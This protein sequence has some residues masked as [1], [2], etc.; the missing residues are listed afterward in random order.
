[1]ESGEE[2]KDASFSDFTERLL[3]ELDVLK[4]EPQSV[5]SKLF[6]PIL[7]FVIGAASIVVASIFLDLWGILLFPVGAFFI[8]VSIGIYSV[9]RRKM[10]KDKNSYIFNR[11][12]LTIRSKVEKKNSFLGVLFLI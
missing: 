9:D 6:Y 5:R 11:E 1:M 3:K 8:I 12:G 2:N 4:L 10:S 7:F